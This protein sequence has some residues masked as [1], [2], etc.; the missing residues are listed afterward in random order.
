MFE[1]LNW[2]DLQSCVAARWTP[3][4][5][6]H[7]ATG[8]PT[9][10]IYGVCALLAARAVARARK[11][12]ERGFWVVMALIMA[13]LALNKQWDLQS[14]LT[15]TGRCISELQGW[16]G[17]RRG[18]QW[19]V[20][21]ALLLAAALGLGLGLHFMRRQLRRNA[22]AVIGLGIVT[23]FLAV[24]AVGFHYFDAILNARFLGVHL[25]FILEVSGL[26]PIALNAILLA[27]W[28]PRQ[29]EDRP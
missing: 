26:V 6:D 25:N 14:A 9:V 22:L 28:G 16:Y 12:R 21:E 17:Q 8:E 10:L 5:G 18:F 2:S 29:S 24:R 20:I 11:G 1:N 15:A 13:F 3:R 27:A 23:A 19:H 7:F 4:M